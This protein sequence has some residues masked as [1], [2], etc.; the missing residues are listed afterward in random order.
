MYILLKLDFK[1]TV[2]IFFNK[3]INI[4]PNPDGAFSTTQRC[5]RRLLRHRRASSGT[6]I[7]IIIMMMMVRAMRDNWNGCG[8]ASHLYEI[9]WPHNGPLCGQG[10]RAHNRC[11]FANQIEN[12]MLP[13]VCVNFEYERMCVMRNFHLNS[14]TVEF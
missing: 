14:D 11:S 9:R 7:Y 12:D 10:A 13:T 2:T 8:L 6:H 5:T 1:N 3:K 4:S